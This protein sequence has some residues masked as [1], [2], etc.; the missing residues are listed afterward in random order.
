ME[1]APKSLAIAYNIQRKNK[2]KKMADGGQVAESPIEKKELKPMGSIAKAIMAKKAKPEP[3]P[4]ETEDDFLSDSFE[5]E[6][7]LSEG[8]D[9]V[10]F[11]DETEESVLDRVFSRLT[12]K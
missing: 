2:A 5:D 6:D 8:M 11:E 9:D 10:P 1:Q 3:E 7:F 4:L 12:N